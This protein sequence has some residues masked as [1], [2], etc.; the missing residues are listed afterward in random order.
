MTIAELADRLDSNP[1]SLIGQSYTSYLQPIQDD[2]GY[3]VLCGD[4]VIIVDFDRT[5][6]E[7]IER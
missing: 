7:V 5:I 6:T 2:S 1:L 4:Y 3:F